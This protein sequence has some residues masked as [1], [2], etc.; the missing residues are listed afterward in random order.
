MNIR[1]LISLLC[2]RTL[3]LLVSL[4]A[5]CLAQ[6]DVTKP[7]TNS[8]AWLNAKLA[9][10][11][12]QLSNNQFSRPIH[13]DSSE[14]TDQSKGDIYALVDYPIAVVS[15]ALNDPTHWCDVMILHINTKYCQPSTDA[16][17]NTILMVRIGKKSYQA[18][19]DAYP[20]EFAHSI[21]NTTPTYFDI[22]FTAKTGPMGTRDY[23]LLLESVAAPNGKT[24]LHLSY[25]YTFNFQGRLAMLLYLSTLGSGKVGFTTTARQ[26]GSPPDF[27][28]GMRGAVERNTMRYY[29]AIEAYLNALSTL[30]AAQLENRLKTWFSATE[31]YPRQLHELDKDSYLD[32]KRREILRMQKAPGSSD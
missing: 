18:L 8:A 31:L 25:S 32:M 4:G 13:L 26:P 20:F 28:G 27:I 23:R 15:E 22:L 29:L 30:P 9:E 21:S 1:C 16:R 14:T 24:F 11:G 17:G 3:V 6:A 7:A 12:P 5:A 10:L 19:E 2:W